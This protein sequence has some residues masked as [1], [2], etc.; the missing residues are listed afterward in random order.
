[1]DQFITILIDDPT[2]EFE[3]H[4]GLIDNKRILFSGRFGSGK[5]Y[6]LKH[7]F[8]RHD[9]FEVFFINPI[10][11]QIA[12]N[13]DI[14]ELI[15]FD[16]I[17]DLLSK[18]WLSKESDSVKNSLLMQF[19][20]LN[21]SDN[22]FFDFLSLLPKLGKIASINK[23]L[24]SFYQSFKDY[25]EA[26]TQ[27]TDIERAE[28]FIKSLESQSG[29][30]NE[31]DPITQLIFSSIKTN[32]TELKESVLIIDDLDRIDPEHIFRIFNV[33]SS[34][35]TEQPNE[36]NKFGFDK[37]ILVCD[38]ENVHKIFHSKY[39]QDVDFS[40]YIDKFY[41][42]RCFNFTN[43]RSILE[44]IDLI[45]KPLYNY[46]S[47]E[48]QQQT[49]DTVKSFLLDFINAKAINIRDLQKIHQLENPFTRRKKYT[50]ANNFTFSQY[51]FGFLGA[52]ILL[53]E[54]F[55]NDLQKIKQYCQKCQSNLGLSSFKN[56]NL[57]IG[58][59]GPFVDITQTNF[60]FGF[61]QDIIVPDLKLV[62]HFKMLKQLSPYENADRINM[63]DISI[64]NHNNDGINLSITQ[65]YNL[66]EKIIINLFKIIS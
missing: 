14:F 6:F 53:M 33:F 18:E 4:L 10:N 65:F 59:L 61:E 11:Y 44:A 51:D 48:N 29:S 9:K 66:F 36:D 43:E 35:F 55:G 21:K 41:S 56:Q 34:H 40:G 50:V 32:K 13:E 63:V 58:Y 26:I 42:Y 49:I 24:T 3:T 5:S 47:N 20:I 16:I 23:S 1:M 22:I 7:F 31:I 30:I 17:L 27:K 52:A 12:K 64:R 46:R 57:I 2:R 28:L 15:K 19:F 60:H 62:V 54:I 8:A 45:F 37:V 39:G 38:I 25:K